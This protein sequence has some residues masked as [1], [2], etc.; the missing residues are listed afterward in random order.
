MLLVLMGLCAA[1]G[2]SSL[3]VVTRAR[4]KAAG[5]AAASDI[6]EIIEWVRTQKEKANAA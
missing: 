2:A 5:D 6:D 1:A 3:Y 4:E